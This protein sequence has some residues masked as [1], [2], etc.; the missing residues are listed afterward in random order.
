MNAVKTPEDIINVP[1]FAALT[2]NTQTVHHEGDERSRT[3]PGHGYPAYTETIKTIDYTVL[4]NE[5]EVTEWVRKHES[6]N[7]YS[8]PTPY[9]IIHVNPVT[10]KT[11][12]AVTVTK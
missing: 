1:H 12:L 3:C 2:F 6:G 4:K 11:E 9:R 7:R 5:S 10:I 8:T